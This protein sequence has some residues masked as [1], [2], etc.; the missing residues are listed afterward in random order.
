MDT[1][2]FLPVPIYFLLCA[3]NIIA[4]NS[5]CNKKVNYFSFI[6]TF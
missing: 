2:N 4:F 3:A 6:N 5:T 1:D